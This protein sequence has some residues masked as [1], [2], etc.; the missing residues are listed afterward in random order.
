MD[1]KERGNWAKSDLTEQCQVK[2]FF[3]KYSEISL[4]LYILSSKNGELPFK[5]TEI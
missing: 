2:T 4:L 3:K 1:F 5:L